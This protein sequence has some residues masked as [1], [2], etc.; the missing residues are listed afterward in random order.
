[1]VLDIVMRSIVI[2]FVDNVLRILAVSHGRIEVV[3][4]I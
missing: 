2:G 3:Q 4:S 1:M